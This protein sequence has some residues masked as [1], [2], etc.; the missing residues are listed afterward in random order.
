MSNESTFK[1]ELV[2]R[3]RAEGAHVTPIENMI[4]NGVPDLHVYHRH[5]DLWIETKGPAS[6]RKDKVILRKSQYAW[7]MQRGYN[8]GDTYIAWQ[9]RNKTLYFA[10][11]YLRHFLPFDAGHVFFSPKDIN[12]FD[13]WDDYIHL[14]MNIRKKYE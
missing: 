8:G 6:L 10:S 5:L 1:T 11:A 13:S 14:G 12:G 9:D 7:L 3:L 2:K 4:G